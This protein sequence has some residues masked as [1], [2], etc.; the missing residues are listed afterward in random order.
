M[1][2]LMVFVI[3]FVDGCCVFGQ[4]CHDGRC[5]QIAG[6]LDPDFAVSVSERAPRS[7]EVRT[8]D[9]ERSWMVSEGL[10]SD[11]VVPP[12]G[13][14]EWESRKGDPLAIQDGL[15][16]DPL[17]IQPSSRVR[18]MPFRKVVDRVRSRLGARQGRFGCQR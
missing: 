9:S 17:A 14:S 10:R 4:S 16:E 1:I 15:K 5:H 2:R 7:S 12:I 13:C 8:N 11:S 18:W 3:V 6:V